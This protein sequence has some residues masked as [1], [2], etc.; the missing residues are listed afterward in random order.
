MFIVLNRI[1][2]TTPSA[3]RRRI[4]PSSVML[5]YSAQT[6]HPRRNLNI[7]IGHLRAEEEGTLQVASVNN[8]TNL[9]PQLL[10]ILSL[11]V[12]ILGLKQLVE[13]RYYVPIDLSL[14]AWNNLSYTGTAYVIGPKSR[15]CSVLRITHWR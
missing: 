10:R 5:H 12:E 14:S 6:N 2:P 15:S 9:I 8:L 13:C 3:S 11:L 7:H 4:W 1:H